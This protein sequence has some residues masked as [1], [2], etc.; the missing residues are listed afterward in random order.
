[1]ARPANGTY[2]SPIIGAAWGLFLTMLAG[3]KLYEAG[4]SLIG[5][6][7]YWIAALILMIGAV[8]SMLHLYRRRQK[9]DG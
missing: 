6:I 8:V 3:V 5:S 4:Y 7:L 1:M 9:T 2:I